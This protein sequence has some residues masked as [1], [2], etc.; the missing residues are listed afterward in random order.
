MVFVFN[1]FV[2]KTALNGQTVKIWYKIWKDRPRFTRSMVQTSILH[3]DF[4]AHPEESA[5]YLA[6]A[7][8]RARAR[9]PS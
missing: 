2:Q 7:R 1:V 9:A 3:R 8:A 6:R 4:Q 5:G